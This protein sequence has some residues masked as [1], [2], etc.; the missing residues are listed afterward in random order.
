[1]HIISIECRVCLSE[2]GRAVS[3]GR[4]RRARKRSRR[5]CQVVEIRW[6]GMIGGCRPYTRVSVSSGGHRP[7]CMGSITDSRF[8]S[9]RSSRSWPPAG[10]KCRTRRSAPGASGSG[11]STPAGCD[12]ERPALATSGISGEVFVKIRGVRKYL[13]RAVDQHGNVLF[14]PHPEREGR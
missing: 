6:S 4:T 8:R 10:S 5:H 11:P 9:V 12:R 14:R 3:I 1:M 2:P 7:L 13:W